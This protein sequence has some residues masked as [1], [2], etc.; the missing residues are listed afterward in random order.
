MFKAHGSMA[1]ET[2]DQT[3]VA[4]IGGPWNLELIREYQAA[5]AP[6]AQALAARGPWALIIVITEAALCPPEAVEAIRE[7]ARFQAREGRRACTCYVIGPE[8]EGAG[9]TDRVW[10]GIYA[11]LMPFEIF[12]AL[13][14]ALAWSARQLAGSGEAR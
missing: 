14:P 5:I 10:R 3:L 12:S 4:R 1:F 8:V 13:E 11:G 7:G 6:R 2:Y 9:L